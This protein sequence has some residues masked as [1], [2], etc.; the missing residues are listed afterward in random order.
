[1]GRYAK[2]YWYTR[3]D[4]YPRALQ[5]P[6]AAVVGKKGLAG[7]FGPDI[8]IGPKQVFGAGTFN[9][10]IAY[11]KFARA[12]HTSGGPWLNVKNRHLGLRF[13]IKGKIHCGWARRT[14]TGCPLS[15]ILTGYAYETIPNKPIMT[16][17]TKGPDE[18]DNSVE[19]AN[20]A[21]LTA[22]TP[23]PASLGLLAFGITRAFHLAAE[24]VGR[25]YGGLTPFSRLHGAPRGNAAEI[26][27]S[28]H[29]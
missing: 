13:T 9:T 10:Y 3:H 27:S 11:C 12:S 16:G 22:P 5:K 20:P 25:C 24:G 21:T 29:C 28:D 2:W 14:T 15:A 23:R 19:V 4:L 17:K 8:T 18:V 6:N 1:L 7:N 26:L